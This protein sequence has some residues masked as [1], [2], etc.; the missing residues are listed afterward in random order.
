MKIGLVILKFLLIG[1]LFILANENIH[2]ADPIERGDFYSKVYGWFDTLYQQ[3]LSI[4]GYVVRSEWLPPES[5][6]LDQ[7]TNQPIG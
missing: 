4:V 7:L 3:S 5:N 1:S 2:L 6:S